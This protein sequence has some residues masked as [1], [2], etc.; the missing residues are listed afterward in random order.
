[1]KT[2]TTAFLVVATLL[3]AHVWMRRA[4]TGA[5]PV[6]QGKSAAI[7]RIFSWV[8]PASPGCAVAASQNGQ[9][10]VNRA[11]GLADVERKVPITP[12]TA[13][14]V[15]SVVKQFVAAAVLLLVEEKRLSL[16]EDVRTVHPGTRPITATGFHW[17]I[18]SR[19][20]AAFATG[21]GCGPRAEARTR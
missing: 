11:Y 12:Q 5:T 3:A 15:G 16:S 20:P 7:D 14:D 2:K 1:M 17:T 19:I 9:L 8:T 18:C 4:N 13:F 6:A 21:S 10:V